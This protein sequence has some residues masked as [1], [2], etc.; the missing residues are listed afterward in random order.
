MSNINLVTIDGPSGSGK[1]TVCHILAQKLQWHLLDSGALYRILAFA[2]LQKKVSLEDQ[3]S[4]ADLALNLD[5][6]F[7]SNGAGV[8]TLLSGENVGDKLRTEVVG[9]AASQVASLPVVRDA[10]LA[11]QK[12][13]NK[14]P[15]LIADGRDMGTVVF[16]D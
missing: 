14:A 6:A 4:L 5:V 15:G 8:D 12:A 3:K 9:Q 16:P 11:R 13:F 1:G 10:L 7:Q 2:A